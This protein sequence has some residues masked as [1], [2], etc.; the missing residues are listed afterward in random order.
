MRAGKSDNSDGDSSGACDCLLV[1]PSYQ[2]VTD[3]IPSAEKAR[4]SIFILL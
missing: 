1:L 4:N 3:D 2:S